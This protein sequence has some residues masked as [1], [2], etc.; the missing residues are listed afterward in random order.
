MTSER[1]P[2]NDNDVNE[3]RRQLRNYFRLITAAKIKQASDADPSTPSFESRN[4]DLY[5]E[6]TLKDGR[7]VKLKAVFHAIEESFQDIHGG[8]FTCTYHVRDTIEGLFKWILDKYP[9][10]TVDEIQDVADELNISFDEAKRTIAF[11]I[12]EREI[13]IRVKMGRFLHDQLKPALEMMVTDLVTDAGL[14]GLSH[15][16]I[17]LSNPKDF[18]RMSKDYTKLRKKRTNVIEGVGKRGKAT[19]SVEEAVEFMESVFTKMRELEH[20]EQK[21][22][23]NAV[24]RKVISHN[25]SNPLKAFKDKLKKYNL[26]FD[27]LKN[28]HQRAESEQKNS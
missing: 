27:N 14:Y 4:N 22:T 2:L 24:A 15:Y 12:A 18:D 28:E 17:K 13:M 16:D 19:V 11:G 3:A 7:K 21:I 8:V 25:H 20:A 9:H 26:T 6:T 10:A 1:T 5:F 23:P